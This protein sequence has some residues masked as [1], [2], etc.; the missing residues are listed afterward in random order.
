MLAVPADILK[1]YNTLL[2]QSSEPEKYH[3]YYR[4]QLR[5]YLDFCR[6]YRTPEQSE[7]S[8]YRFIE[9]LGEKRQPEAYLKQA[10]S[11]VSLYYRI[12]DGSEN[13]SDN[14]TKE[15]YPEQS[16]LSQSDRRI[17]Y[18]G[19]NVLTETKT[20]TVNKLMDSPDNKRLTPYQHKNTII[21]RPPDIRNR[22]AATGT[23]LNF[24]LVSGKRAFGAN[25]LR[26]LLAML[27]P[28]T[29]ISL[30]SQPEL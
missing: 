5:Y 8:L 23:A 25:A 15:G 1:L 13:K 3:S 29:L 17:S 16:V 21:N 28:S 6:T 14:T 19:K 22:S 2:T 11:A 10:S 7:S 24:G 12:I 18:G 27:T 4:K 9:K 20:A 26:Q 30:I